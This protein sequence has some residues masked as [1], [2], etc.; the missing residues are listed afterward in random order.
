[1]KHRIR[2]RGQKGEP[3]EVK[4][5]DGNALKTQFLELLERVGRKDT[6]RGEYRFVSQPNL[7]QLLV[8]EMKI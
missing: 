1:M 2:K 5:M 6:E 8:I 3:K 4:S 7:G